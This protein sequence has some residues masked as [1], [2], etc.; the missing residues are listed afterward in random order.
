MKFFKW[1]IF[2]DSFQDF[3]KQDYRAKNYKM[4]ELN[5]IKLKQNKYKS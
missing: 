3:S 2:M 4:K 1:I 5:L